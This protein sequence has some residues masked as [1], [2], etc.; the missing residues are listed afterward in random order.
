MLTLV[1]GMLPL[2]MLWMHMVHS[3]LPL[4]LDVAVTAPLHVHL[5]RGRW[6]RNC[7][8]LCGTPCSLI[9][10]AGVAWLALAADA[11]IGNRPAGTQD[12]DVLRELA[13]NKDKGSTGVV[14]QFAPRL[15]GQG[16]EG[17]AKL[18]NEKIHDGCSEGR[19]LRHCQVVVE[20]LEGESLDIEAQLRRGANI[21][22]QQSET[23]HVAHALHCLWSC[24]EVTQRR[25]C[26]DHGCVDREA[27]FFTP[28]A[29]LDHRFPR[30]SDLF[31]SI[32]R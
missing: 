4:P 3:L 21:L 30:I 8:L 27:N 2:V 26:L 1:V 19:K 13:A 5:K 20:V 16:R 25:Q 14:Q 17:L 15:L 28:I 18:G 9:G 24:E 6:R 11:T 32:R 12:L 7:C 23:M 22:H 31:N 10:V 29:G